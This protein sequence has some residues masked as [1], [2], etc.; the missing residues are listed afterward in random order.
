MM[1]SAV[2]GAVRLAIVPCVRRVPRKTAV[3]R[4]S[5]TDWGGVEGYE[6]T[7]CLRTAGRL[8]TA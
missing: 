3:T 5:A 2:A 1:R 8:L 4:G 7:G 6:R